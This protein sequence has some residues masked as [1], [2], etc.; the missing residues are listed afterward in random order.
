MV[1]AATQMDGLF[2]SRF[3]FWG[4]AGFKKTDWFKLPI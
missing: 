4:F 2:L 3:R 1:I